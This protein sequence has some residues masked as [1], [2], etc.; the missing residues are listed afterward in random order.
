[1]DPPRLRNNVLRRTARAVA[2]ISFWYNYFFPVPRR[3]IEDFS[4]QAIFPIVLDVEIQPGRSHLTGGCSEQTA[5][6]CATACR[7]GP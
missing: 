1:M 2:N 3:V 6:A 5:D 4:Q 7:Q